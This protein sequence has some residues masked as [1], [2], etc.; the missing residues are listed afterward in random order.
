MVEKQGQLGLPNKG[1]ITNKDMK[2]RKLMAFLMLIITMSL[3]AQTITVEKSYRL[4]GENLKGFFPVLNMDGNM[5]AFTS[6]SYQGLRVYDF[7]TKSVTTISTEPGAGLNPVFNSNNEILYRNTVY[8]SKLRYD[9][10]KSFD[11]SKKITTEI[12]EPQRDIRYAKNQDN[13]IVLLN[14]KNEIKSLSGKNE[15]DAAYFVWSDG[16]SLNIKT[17][18]SSKVLNP[19]ED[20]NGYIWASLS[21]DGK[22][23]LFHA[24]AKGTFVCDLQGNIISSLGHLNAPVWYGNNYVVGMQDKDNGENIISST[25]IVKSMDGKVEKQISDSEHIAMY[26]TASPIAGK[27][28]YCTNNGDIYV[29]ELN[30][31]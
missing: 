13:N 22:K 27:V 29:V 8:K 23:I 3:S 14:G 31:N 20:A 24:V 30:V 5:L 21:P 6:E 17:S 15:D 25:I 18:N 4:S 19:V 11:L 16:K 7:S 2:I 28:A 1:L 26:P 9:G 10:I 12:I